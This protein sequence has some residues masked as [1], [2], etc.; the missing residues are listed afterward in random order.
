M[1]R[2]MHWLTF[3]HMHMRARLSD[4]NRMVLHALVRSTRRL[5]RTAQPIPFVNTCAKSVAVRSATAE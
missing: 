4:V 3:V 2:T 5:F 1:W